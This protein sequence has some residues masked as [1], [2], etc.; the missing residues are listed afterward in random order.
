[1]NDLIRTFNY[2]NVRTVNVFK[3]IERLTNNIENKLPYLLF[4]VILLFMYSIV[5]LYLWNF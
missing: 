3:V 5:I 1:M 2:Y 4:F